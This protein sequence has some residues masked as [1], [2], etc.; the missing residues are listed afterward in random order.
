MFCITSTIRSVLWN[1]DKLLGFKPK[2]GLRQGDPLSPYLFFLCMERLS[3]LISSAVQDG[4]WKPVT[5]RGSNLKL[6]HLLFADDLLLFIRANVEQVTLAKDILAS[7]CKASGLR[8]NEG[9]SRAMGQKNLSQVMK[10]RLSDLTGISFSSN[11]GKYL[12]FPIFSTRATI[13]DFQFLVDRVNSRVASWKHHLL[14]RAGKTTLAQSVLSSMST[15]CMQ[16]AWIPTGVC[17]DI[18]AAIRRKLGGLGLRKARDHVT[19]LLGENVWQVIN[20]ER[21]PWAIQKARDV[22]IEGFS[23]K[24]GNGSSSFWYDEWLGNYKICD[25]VPAVD[26]HDLQLGVRDVIIGDAW[27]LDNL[28]TSLPSAV[29][30]EIVKRES[31]LS[32]DVPD[33]MVWSFD[34]SGVYSASSGYHWLIHQRR[35]QAA[36]GLLPPPNAAG[37][38]WIWRLKRPYKIL[39]LI[40]LGCHNALPVNHLRFSRHM[41]ALPVCSR[42]N[43]YP[44]TVMH[45]LRDCW[46][47]RRVWLHLG[48]S[49]RHDSFSMLALCDWL[50]QV[51]GEAEATSLAAIW[52]IWQRRT[53]RCLIKL[54]CRRT[55]SYRTFLSSSD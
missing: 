45:C 42:C 11:I 31:F 12:G 18:D 6:S 37:W 10:S 16:H 24:L 28:Y 23:Y 13:R 17:D 25:L 4:R 41:A 15:Y 52:E 44:E 34:S 1:G 38:Q 47:A 8:V 51:L 20:G 53:W 54:C 3:S 49:P 36:D 29:S 7:F 30:E 9:K 43:L 27:N 33:C 2:R 19:A 14:N 5:V 46:F 22:I 40:W 26:I 50:K 35:V 39:F 32:A 48:L 21:K 55:A